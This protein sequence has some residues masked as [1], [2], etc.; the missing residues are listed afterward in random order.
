MW[1]IRRSDERIVRDVQAFPECL[2]LRCQLIAMGL[3]VDAGFGRS[4]LNFLS[5]FIESGEKEDVASSQA[6]VASQDVGRHGGVG[7]ADMRH[8]VD[9][10]NRGRDVEGGSRA[11]IWRE[12]KISG[13][14]RL[15][16]GWRLRTG[17][18]PSCFAQA[19][20]DR[21]QRHVEVEVPRGLLFGQ[22]NLTEQVQERIDVGPLRVCFAAS[23][24]SSR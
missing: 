19:E 10:V 4:L 22:F 3:R 6:P 9:V 13:W 17:T 11:L 1:C 2:K 7:M 24:R 8:V 23:V 5:M 20:Q 12:Q 21:F 16:L 14:R 18:R 15:W